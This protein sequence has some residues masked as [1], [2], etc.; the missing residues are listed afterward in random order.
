MSTDLT[1]ALDLDA[2]RHRVDTVLAD[3]LRR[4]PSTV[5]SQR[6]CGD[7]LAQALRDFVLAPGKRIRALLCVLGWQ[8]AAGADGEEALWRTA[9][10]LEIFH[11]FALIHDDI[12]DSSQTRR[13]RPSAHRAFA[14][15]HRSRP[16][17]DTFGIHA[18]ILL[19]DLALTCSDALMNTAGLSTRQRD[20]VLPLIDTMRGEVLLGQHMDLMATGGPTDDVERAMTIARLKTAK[21]TV[22]RPLHLG[23]ALAGADRELFGLCSAYALP[24]GEAF[25]LRDDLLGVFGDPALTGKPVLDDLRSGKATVLMALALRH[26]T[27]HQRRTL[28]ALV[29]RPD[30][31]AEGAGRVRRILQRTGARDM[32]EGMITERYEAALRTLD[33][34]ALT[35]QTIHALRHIA[36]R[37][38][39]RTT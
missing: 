39:V 29:G 8:A 6:G 9:A 3:F 27:P 13:G 37:A 4:P 20:T 24:L 5:P 36:T 32:V 31:D 28:E 16:D 10:S 26:A 1:E 15:R 19:G 7:E 38:V 17:A 22:E 35:P 2:I 21:Y 33:T 23:A 11:A 14:A 18:A 34:C 25:Q 30:L 12:I